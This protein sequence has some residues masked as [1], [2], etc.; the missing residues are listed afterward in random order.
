MVECFVFL[1][2]LGLRLAL[3][4]GVEDNSYVAT[5]RPEFPVAL[6]NSLPDSQVSYT[7]SLDGG[8]WHTP[9]IDK[10]VAVDHLTEGEHKLSI[11]AIEDTAM[12]ATANLTPTSRIVA[13]SF[14]EPRSW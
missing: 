13:M 9:V 2:P 8:F 7:Y 5:D 4:N 3:F 11:R 10:K 6:K 14:C 1:R 12:G